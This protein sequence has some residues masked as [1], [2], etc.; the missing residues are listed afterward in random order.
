MSTS[1]RL[2]EE[3]RRLLDRLARDERKSKSD[4]IREAIREHGK[5]RSTENVGL[6]V[7]DSIR[8][9]V[10]IV[11]GGDP[12][13]SQRTGERFAEIVRVKARGRRD[14]ASREKRTARHT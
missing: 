1:L 10:G 2:D 3:T 11:E 5:A 12:T 13:L 8:H 6:S 7:Y 9:L 14:T 4:V